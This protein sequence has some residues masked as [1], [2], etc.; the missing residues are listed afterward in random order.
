MIADMPQAV[1]LTRLTDVLLADARFSA[2]IVFGS[3]ARG[4]QRADSD[5]DLAVVYADDQA[6]DSVERELLTVL[7]HLALAT[8]RD[9]HLIDLERVDVS[10][11]R[12]VFEG[13]MV[14]VDR[15]RRRLRDLRSAT[16]IEYLDWA[17]AR[18]VVDAAHARRLAAHDG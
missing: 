4:T 9:V 14:L 16:G 17:Y 10:L 3:V 8:D 1:D 11:R 2:A 15:A 6:R 12:A 18:S 13:G 7:G 5:L